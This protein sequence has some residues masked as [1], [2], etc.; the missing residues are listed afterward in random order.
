MCAFFYFLRDTC[1]A[2]CKCE[3]R[4]DLTGHVHHPTVAHS[5]DLIGLAEQA[6][7]TDAV[8]VVSWELLFAGRAAVPPGLGQVGQLSTQRFIRPQSK[9][10]GVSSCRE[11]NNSVLCDEEDLPSAPDMKQRSGSPERHRSPAGG[12][13]E[14]RPDCGSELGCR[15]PGTS[16]LQDETVHGQGALYKGRVQGDFRWLPHLT[17]WTQ[18]EANRKLYFSHVLKIAQYG[19]ILCDNYNASTN[20]RQCILFRNFPLQITFFTL[21]ECSQK[22]HYL[23][24]MTQRN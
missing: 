1:R 22:M 3:V 10:A 4:G 8:C 2:L 17:A 13:R 5:Q 20:L 9:P 6:T 18:F 16:H 24:Y 7:G 21:L 15:P 23:Q 19:L 14:A 12:C 11:H